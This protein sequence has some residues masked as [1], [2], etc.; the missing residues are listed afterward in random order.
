ML[1]ITREGIEM[2][3]NAVGDKKSKLVLWIFD[4][5]DSENNLVMTQEEIVK[6]TGMSS[7]TV[8]LTMKALLDNNILIKIN[9]GAYKLNL[10]NESN[11]KDL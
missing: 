3:V 7:Q 10:E 2:I 6:R 9:S 4:N 11:K 5:L 1:L 8:N